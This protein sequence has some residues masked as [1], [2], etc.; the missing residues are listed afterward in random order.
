MSRNETLSKLRELLILRRTALSRALEG[1]LSL[2]REFHQEKTGDLLD[3]AADSV[4]DELH[5]QLIE[6]E[7]RE[8]VLIDEAIERCDKGTYGECEACGKNIPLT[9][10]RVVPYATEC[11]ECRRKSEQ[12]EQSPTAALWNRSFNPNEV[13]AV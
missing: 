11:I 8:L 3:A 12:R 4:Q 10:L 2:L 6:A 13:D 9:R 1:D 5:G 7:G